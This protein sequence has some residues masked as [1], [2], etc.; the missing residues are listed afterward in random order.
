[1]NFAAF[2]NGKFY[3]LLMALPLILWFGNGAVQLR[4]R[5]VAD[6]AMILSGQAGLFIGLQFCALL[7]SAVFNL[8]LVWLLVVRQPPVLRA[9]GLL[10]RLTGFA[11]T[12]L[13]VSILHLPVAPLNLFWQSVAAL[14]VL[15]GSAGS[16]V[17]LLK[18]GKAFSIMPE[19]RSL[20]TGGPYAYAR[21]PLYAAELIIIIGT[22]IQFQQPWAA[23]LAL[24]VMPLIW[25]RTV[26]EEQVL[27]EAW[28][29]YAA[30]RARTRRF[31]PG[32]I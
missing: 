4:P 9:R 10:P 23:L 8:V 21:H 17:I 11:G 25:A 32:L 18:L 14:L 2:R 19:A 31:I 27:L 22:A 13:G 12:F 28:P 20:V 29:E 15:A 5:L 30:Y 24:A 7:A 6:A 1:M 3:D 26:F 16:A